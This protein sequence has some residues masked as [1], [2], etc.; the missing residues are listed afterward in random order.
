MNA[1][2]LIGWNDCLEKQVMTLTVQ[3]NCLR[4]GVMAYNLPL[5]YGKF[6]LGRI[7][8][9][10]IKFYYYNNYNNY[11]QILH[12]LI[13]QLFITVSSKHKPPSLIIKFLHV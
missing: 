4:E 6:I 12:E 1:M 3:K 7:Y 2:T 8:F 9:N 10:L 13:L 11:I 5:I